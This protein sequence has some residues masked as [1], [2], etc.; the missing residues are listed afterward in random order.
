MPVGHDEGR[1][2]LA[3]GHERWREYALS[4]E[5][6]LTDAELAAEW[7]DWISHLKHLQWSE[8]ASENPLTDEQWAPVNARA[9]TLWRFA[10][11]DHY[12]EGDS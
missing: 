9:M 7:H 8:L 2:R 4:D 3:W 12:D 1:Q 5:K 11:H 10:T 6:R